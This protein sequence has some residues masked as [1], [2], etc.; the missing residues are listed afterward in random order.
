MVESLHAQA[1]HP[2][3]WITDVAEITDPA[4]NAANSARTNEAAAAHLKSFGGEYL[5][6]TDRITAMDGTQPKRVIIARF[7]DA[8]KAKAWYNSPEQKKVVD[9]RLKTTKS[10]SFIVDGL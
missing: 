8:E 10:R 2:V 5:A 1:K 7:P 6:R 9:V 3:Y 4:G